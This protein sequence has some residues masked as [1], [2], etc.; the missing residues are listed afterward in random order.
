MTTQAFT[1]LTSDGAALLSGGAGPDLLAVLPADDAATSDLTGEGGN[2]LL[3][4][5]ALGIG[6]LSGGQGDDTLLGSHAA[7]DLDALAGTGQIDLAVLFRDDGWADLLYG[8]AGDDWLVMGIGDIGYGGLGNDTLDLRFSSGAARLFGGDGTDAVVLNMG[9]GDSYT[10]LDEG[11]GTDQ[12]FSVA[13]FGRAVQAAGLEVLRLGNALAP[14]GSLFTHVLGSGDQIFIPDQRLTA[15]A[16]VVLTPLQ[17]DYA[18][19]GGVPGEGFTIRG[20]LGD[21]TGTGEL[22]IIGDSVA[23]HAAHGS[24]ATRF[25][26]LTFQSAQN[27]VYG[28][29]TLEGLSYAQAAP[30]V[31]MLA[32]EA[33]AGRTL[34]LGGS[35]HDVTVLVRNAFLSVWLSEQTFV[36]FA[37]ARVEVFYTLPDALDL[38]GTSGLMQGATVAGNAAANAVRGSDLDDAIA[39][40]AGDD[41]L[42]GA[43]GNDRLDGDSGDDRLNGGAGRDTLTGGDG[44]DLLRGGRGVDVLSGGDGD[45]D[46]SGGQQGDLLSGGT[47]H[48][49][50]WGD[51]GDDRLNGDAGDDDLFG[52]DGADI[53]SGGTG[54][55][56][57][58]GG[59]LSDRLGGGAGRDLLFGGAGNDTLAGGGDRDVL[60]GGDGDDVL[61][62]DAGGDTLSGGA[63]NDTLAGGAG[64]DLFVLADNPS[65]PPGRVVIADFTIGPGGDRL[66]LEGPAHALTAADLRALM[67]ADG[68]DTILMLPGRQIVFPDLAPDAFA[69]SD[70]WLAAL[71]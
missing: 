39:G 25:G 49:T 60:Y 4:G 71:I 36:D 6:F 20:M 21:R 68:G 61:S 53:L 3:L 47:G 5:G 70:D 59:D 27:P 24:Y 32:Q 48:D 12:T 22:R 7:T 14:D 15:A 69:L 54:A 67:Q 51:I 10:V 65:G 8:D 17:I 2:D 38:R 26:T 13:A 42:T 64:P 57:L 44:N 35:V 19:D 37:L 43:D 30:S 9:L 23:T 58:D 16:P 63:G 31:A 29:F 28:L 45:D 33:N 41:S 66:I 1:L 46:L 34:T 52:G 62:G 55:D 56:T 40:A 50:V 18:S 11:F